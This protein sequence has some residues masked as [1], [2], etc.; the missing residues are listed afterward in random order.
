MRGAGLALFATV[1]LVG[2]AA[3]IAPP[4]PAEPIVDGQ[5]GAVSRADIHWIVVTAKKALR[6]SGRGSEPI[7]RVHIYDRDFI[8]VSHGRLPT[9]HDT[10]EERLHFH[11][12]KGHWHLDENETVRGF[13]I[14][15]G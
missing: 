6:D 4:P 5:T 12:I 7:F 15:T 2:C 14:P 11:R 3:E 10:T 8:S 13:N 9:P 1:L